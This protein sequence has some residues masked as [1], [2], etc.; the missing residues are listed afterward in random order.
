ML[1]ICILGENQVKDSVIGNDGHDFIMAYWQR[2]GRGGG[3]LVLYDI[4]DSGLGSRGGIKVEQVL[5][6]GLLLYLDCKVPS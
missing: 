1:A 3:S 2:S 6:H 5:V 4:I